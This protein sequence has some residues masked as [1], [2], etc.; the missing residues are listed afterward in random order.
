MPQTLRFAACGGTYKQPRLKNNNNEMNS[1]SAINEY[2]RLTI[3]EIQPLS[4]T[5]PIS[6]NKNKQSNNNK[7]PQIVAA[8]MTQSIFL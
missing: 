7:N 2:V 8:T 6:T 5:K 1:P 4:V 3:S